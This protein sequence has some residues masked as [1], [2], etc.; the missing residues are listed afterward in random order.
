MVL[1][2]Y[3]IH[4]HQET[5]GTLKKGNWGGI[6]WNPYK[7]VL[8]LVSQSCLTLCDPMDCS[9]LGSSVH[10]DSPGK[11]TGMGCH[12]LLQGN[13]P[14][15]GVEPRSLSLQADSLPSEPPE[16]Y[17]LGSVIQN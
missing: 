14:N 2:L 8:C 7:G 6:E 4:T 15:L 5:N 16:A 13:F 17:S 11:N 3:G 10:G 1:V 9:P 12:D